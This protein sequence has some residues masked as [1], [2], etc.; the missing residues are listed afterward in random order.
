MI[1]TTNSLPPPHCSNE[2]LAILE[3]VVGI[4]T[5]FDPQQ[6]EQDRSWHSTTVNFKNCVKIIT[7]NEARTLRNIPIKKIKHCNQD[8]CS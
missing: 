7:Q 4:V 8:N 2:L 3:M 1:A 6:D 5:F